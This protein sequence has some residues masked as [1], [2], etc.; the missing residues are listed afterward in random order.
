M[1]LCLGFLCH[2]S[3]TP[4]DT[5]YT[6]VESLMKEV[7]STKKKMAT[8]YL[9]LDTKED[10]EIKIRIDLKQIDCEIPIYKSESFD[11]KKLMT[12]KE[13]SL[14]DPNQ[15]LEVIDAKSIE[16]R[17]LKNEIKTL[18]KNLN[19]LK[20]DT[21]SLDS[22][23]IA[24]VEEDLKDKRQDF[25]KV[26]G[27]ATKL[28]NEYEAMMDSLMGNLRSQYKERLVTAMEEA[29]EKIENKETTFK[30]VDDDGTFWDIRLDLLKIDATREMK[31]PRRLEKGEETTEK[32]TAG[33]LYYLLHFAE[34]GAW[35]EREEVTNVF[36]SIKLW[37]FHLNP[38]LVNKQFGLVCNDQYRTQ[39]Y[40]NSVVDYKS[41]KGSLVEEEEFADNNPLAFMELRKFSGG[42]AQEYVG[43]F[44]CVRYFNGYS[45]SHDD[46]L[47][48]IQGKNK[49]HMGVDLLAPINTEV[50]SAVEGIAY[51][52]P[53]E[54]R[55]YGKTISVKGKLKNLNTG[56]LEEIYVMYAHLNSISIENGANVKVGDVLGRT[57]IT[58]NGDTKK[59]DERHLHLEILTQKW[60]SSAK[61]FSIRKPPLQYFKVI[62]P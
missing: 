40:I 61:G 17:R 8:Y 48:A 21:L 50:F 57:G 3:P 15:K 62:N 12:L 20:A 38:Y 27:E 16:W 59:K 11:I 55:G 13:E 25:R 52:Y 18:T 60:P 28:F 35:Y 14:T 58:G 19:A 4:K 43:K 29:Y 37:E 30:S 33:K 51:V 41:Y 6:N 1:I 32:I 24:K 45:C 42:Y 47:Y 7:K 22:T 56:E 36:S 34:F 53:G 5:I 54:I 31:I 46:P 23:A 9:V 49:A 10:K 2:A 44:G 39:H 26:D